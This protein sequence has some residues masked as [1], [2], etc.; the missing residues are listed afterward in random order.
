M[1]LN[2]GVLLMFFLFLSCGG[3]SS[4]TDNPQVPI[5]T[6]NPEVPTAPVEPCTSHLSPYKTQL[7]VGQ[8]HIGNDENWQERIDTMD[9][10]GVQSVRLN[11]KSNGEHYLESIVYAGHLGMDVLLSISLMDSWYFPT[12]TQKREGNGKIKDQYRISEIDLEKYEN[13]VGEIFASLDAQ[14]SNLSIIEVGSEINWADFNGDLPVLDKGRFVTF[15]DELGDDRENVLKGFEKYAELI[16]IT[17]ELM[18]QSTH[19]KD[20]L[21]ISAGLAS[22]GSA[23]AFTNWFQNS[24]GTMMSIE[25]VNDIY[26][27]LGIPEFIDGRGIHIFSRVDEEMPLDERFQIT[28]ETVTKG[29]DVCAPEKEPCYITEW[30]FNSDFDGCVED[31]PREPLFQEFLSAVSCTNKFPVAWVFTWDGHETKK[32]YRCNRNTSFGGELVS[33]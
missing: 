8:L 14:K 23:G 12:D 22:S 32:I 26:D 17:R 4:S 28:M 3:N 24:G 2:V 25:L 27:E 10:A 18:D 19:Q 15:L 1:K 11:I 31:D 9:D 5:D 20:T 29:A 7:G 16:R 30:G 21:L 13:V 6:E 33:N